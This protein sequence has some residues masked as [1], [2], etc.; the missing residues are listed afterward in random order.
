MSTFLVVIK[1]TALAKVDLGYF[2]VMPKKK[3]VY[4]PFLERY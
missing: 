3:K 1:I 2:N 4:I